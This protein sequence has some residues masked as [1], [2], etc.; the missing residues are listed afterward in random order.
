MTRLEL[1]HTIQDNAEKLELLD[2][3]SLLASR[4]PTNDTAVMATWA[5]F[6]DALAANPATH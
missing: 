1:L 3:F 5:A 4:L 2:A 6:A